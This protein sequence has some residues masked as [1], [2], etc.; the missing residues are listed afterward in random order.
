MTIASTSGQ[1][2]APFVA[3]ARQHSGSA[4]EQQAAW[5]FQQIS[6]LRAP[7]IRPGRGAPNDG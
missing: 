5:P 2:F 7:R 6:G 3:Q 4:I 1:P